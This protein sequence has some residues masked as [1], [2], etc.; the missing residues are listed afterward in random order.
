MDFSLGIEF[1][2]FDEQISDSQSNLPIIKKDDF[3]G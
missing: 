2:F 1:D 3:S